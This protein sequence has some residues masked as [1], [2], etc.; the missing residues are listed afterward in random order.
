MWCI[1]KKEIFK[2]RANPSNVL[3]GSKCLPLK[4]YF[5]FGNGRKSFGAYD[6]V[7]A[8]TYHDIYNEKCISVLGPQFLMQA[9]KAFANS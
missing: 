8:Y 6:I 2:I 3:H 7:R 9:P 5:I 1:V 4:V